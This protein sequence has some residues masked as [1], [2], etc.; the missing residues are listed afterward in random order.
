[1]PIGCTA[2]QRSWTNP[3]SVSSPEREPPPTSG[4]A[5]STSTCA[6]ACCRR[7]PAA[8]PFGPAPTISA[9]IIFLGGPWLAFSQL[10]HVEGALFEEPAGGVVDAVLEPR[11]QER[12][13]LHK[14]AAQLA[15]LKPALILNGAEQA[16]AVQVPVAE[17]PAEGQPGHPPAVD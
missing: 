14:D 1:M 11:A 9:S 2:E 12:L 7:T 16:L 8:R 4:A 10:A 3:G 17:V 15:R 6:P 5:S 13:P